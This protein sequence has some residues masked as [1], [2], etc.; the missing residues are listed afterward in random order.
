M[1]C[2]SACSDPMRSQTNKPI[3]LDEGETSVRE[4][5]RIKNV[6]PEKK[7]VGRNACREKS[8]ASLVEWKS[9]LDV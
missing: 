4:L 7:P 2:L 3:R 6:L 9:V 1:F 8:E 5:G